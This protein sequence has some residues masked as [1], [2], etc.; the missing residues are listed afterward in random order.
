MT[1]EEA[2]DKGGGSICTIID[3][4]ARAWDSFYFSYGLLD[5][6]N[7][8]SLPLMQGSLHFSQSD[9]GVVV[10]NLARLDRFY[11]SSFFGDCSGSMGIFSGIVS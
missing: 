5:L 1:I 9:D 11:A 6:W 7:I 8:H 3:Q 10:A 2:F 4:E